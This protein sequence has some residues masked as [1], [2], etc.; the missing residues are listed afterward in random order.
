MPGSDYLPPKRDISPLRDFTL[1]GAGFA[2]YAITF[3]EQF[4]NK[5]VSVLIV[6]P[7][8]RDLEFLIHEFTQGR[9]HLSSLSE[10]ELF[11]SWLRQRHGFIQAESMT[12]IQIPVKDLK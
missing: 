4:Q 8:D 3:E 2:I 9:G 7:A 5:H 1:A 10:C 11:I 6:G 12:A